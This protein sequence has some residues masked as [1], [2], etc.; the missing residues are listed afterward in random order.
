MASK[1]SLTLDYFFLR[2]K[3]YGGFSHGQAGRRGTN[4]RVG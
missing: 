2:G 4:S 3:D 1:G